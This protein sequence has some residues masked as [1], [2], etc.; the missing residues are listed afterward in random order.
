V[1]PILVFNSELIIRYS[2]SELVSSYIS[3]ELTSFFLFT[4][5]FVQQFLLSYPFVDY[6]LAWQYL[7]TFI[8]RIAKTF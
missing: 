3:M 1:A 7:H 6:P 2:K 8:D 5:F 4:F